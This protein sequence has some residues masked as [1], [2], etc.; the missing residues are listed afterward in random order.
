M[1]MLQNAVSRQ[2]TVVTNA[3]WDR[4]YRDDAGDV[5]GVGAVRPDGSVEQIGCRALIIATGF[6]A[7]RDVGRIYSGNYRSPLLRP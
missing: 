6:G 4:V 5:L 2:V 1:A 7:G 3:R